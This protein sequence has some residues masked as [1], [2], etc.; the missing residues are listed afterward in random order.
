MRFQ[1]I[2]PLRRRA[3]ICETTPA[4]VPVLDINAFILTRWAW[5]AEESFNP[6]PH[7]Q[8][9]VC[10]QK[11]ALKQPAFILLI[12]VY[13]NTAYFPAVFVPENLWPVGFDTVENP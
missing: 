3:L 4:S 10:H 13:D 12:Y 9:I 1:K 11:H 6:S 7:N 5:L 2:S 8:M